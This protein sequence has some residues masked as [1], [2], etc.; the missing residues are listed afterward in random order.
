MDDMKSGVGV[1][2]D[3]VV[4]GILALF[5]TMSIHYFWTA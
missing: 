5:M 3:D 4:A 1:M 2:M